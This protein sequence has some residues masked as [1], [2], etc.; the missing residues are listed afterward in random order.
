MVDK[1]FDIVGIGNSIVDV[2]A[3]IDDQYLVEHKVFEDC[4]KKS[5]ISI[6][7]EHQTL[8]PNIENPTISINYIK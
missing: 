4:L 3:D 2:I 8:F 7:T 1:S 6:N 5:G